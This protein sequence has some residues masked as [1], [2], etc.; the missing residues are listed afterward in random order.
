MNNATR[1]SVIA[2]DGYRILLD[3]SPQALVVHRNFVPCYANRALAE[4]FGYRNQ[5]EVLRLSSVLELVEP[6]EHDRVRAIANARLAGENPPQ[7]YETLGV[8]KDG[9]PFWVE[10]TASVVLWDGDPCVQVWY[11][12][13]SRRKLA[14][15]Q[16]RDGRR[17]L[18]TVIDS[19]PMF[20]F[21]KDLES[22]YVMVNK[23]MR[24]FYN[25]EQGEFATMSPTSLPIQSGEEKEMILGD[26]RVVFETRQ[27]YIQPVVPV[28]KPDGTPTFRYS[29]KIP[30]FDDDGEL[31]GLL[32][33]GEDITERK[34]VEQD[35]QRV[36]DELEQRVEDRTAALRQ[37]E[38]ALTAS[39]AELRK[40]AGDL[41]AAQEAERRSIARELHDDLTQRLAIL[42][43]D[44]DQLGR[45]HPEVHERMRVELRDLQSRIADIASDAQGMARRLHPSILDDLG[46]MKALRAECTH[47]SNREGIDVAFEHRDVPNSL[48]R[49]LALCLYRVAQESLRNI[50]KHA[51]SP[52]AVVE[53]VGTGG[54]EIRLCVED[55]GVGFSLP[56]ADGKGL[57]LISMRERARLNGGAYV[58]RSVPG[59][60]TRIDVRL[61]L[62]GE[63][64]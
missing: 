19:L 18:R 29:I 33:V 7:R 38:T 46:L 26:D 56:D 32:G 22:N 50:G 23:T 51:D 60:G 61:P 16:V 10:I 17:L 44:V 14:E 40:L 58:V 59:E 30:L 15:D 9:T 64:I 48:P 1:A 6:V 31:T 54:G 4:L 47:F 35:L 63:P 27:P 43:L 52:D 53:L 34:R 41:L 11:R 37:S 2:D 25:L 21:V 57:G 5:E 49:G 20:V 36:Y 55:H 12:D 28:T 45:D 39:Q 42:A 3:A 13:V 24:D 8:R 62:G